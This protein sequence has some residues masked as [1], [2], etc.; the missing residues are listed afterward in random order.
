[1]KSEIIIIGAG[2]AGLMA[3][4]ELSKAG[5]KVIILEARDRVG[6]RI[7][8]LD[9]KEF[10]YP[11]QGGAE[12]IHGL[13][14]VTKSIIKEAGL[15]YM[16][17]SDD[18]GEMWSVWDGKL[19]RLQEIVPQKELLHERLK[20]LEEDMPIAVFL[21]KYFSE[22]QYADLRNYVIKM[23]EDYDAA[24]SYKISAFS[25]REEWLGGEEWEQGRIKEGY[26]PLLSFLK[27]ECERSGV[28]IKLNQEVTSVE[29]K[30]TGV[31]VV[32]KNED[33]YDAQQIVVTAPVSI[34]NQIHF[35]PTLPEKMAAAAKVGF[36][37]VVKIILLFKDQWWVNARGEDL[38][39]LRFMRSNE[40]IPIWWTQYPDLYPVLTGWL[41]GPNAEK[42]KELSSDQVID[43]AFTSLASIFS[44]DEGK[45]RERLVTVK[46]INWSVD[47]LARGAYSY[48]TVGAEEAYKEL[49]EPVDDK[50]F[51][52]GEALC[53]GKETATV[54][55]ALVSGLEV[56]KKIMT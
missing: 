36:G 9:E 49:G 19:K 50:I 35:M 30:D 2:A 6:G 4:R 22:E 3:A 15:T 8:P 14:P 11:A 46:V 21:D 40:K 27:S 1:M 52:A 24:D 34:L 54:E 18:D 39:K 12:F 53:E 26:T 48:S 47:P 13:A 44:I 31:R 43:A 51:F 37:Q 56:A 45:L 33:K 20:E 7:F 23:A 28:M 10:G 38:S 32:C 42:V 41:A 5:K 29:M 16:H 17:T 25:L 55:G